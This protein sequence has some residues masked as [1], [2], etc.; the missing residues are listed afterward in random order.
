M[1]RRY[2]NR[3]QS[4]CAEGGAQR[5]HSAVGSA[6]ALLPTV[7]WVGVGASVPA[8]YPIMPVPAVVLRSS[9]MLTS[10]VLQPFAVDDESSQRK[11]GATEKRAVWK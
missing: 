2:R 6:I 7:S 5:P 9:T 1:V 10:I 4:H 3:K 11:P 8:C